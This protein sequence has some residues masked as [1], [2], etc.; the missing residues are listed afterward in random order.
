MRLWDRVQNLLG[1][2]ARQHHLIALRDGMIAVV[3]IILVGS[4]FLLLGSQSEVINGYFPGLAK[5]NFGIWYQNNFGILLAPF[6]FTMGMLSLY[7]AFT[8]A[9]SLAAQYK[10]PVLPQGMASVVAFLITIKPYN[11]PVEEGGKSVWLI[12][13]KPLGGDG[14]FLAIICGIFTVELSRG[15]NWLWNRLLQRGKKAD[16]AGEKE[17]DTG[18]SA[19][20][21]PKAVVDAFAS[22]LPMLSVVTLFWILCYSL[23]IDLYNG[24]IYLMRP[25][26]KMGDTL[27]CVVVVN[28]FLH[29]VGVAGV[30]GVSVINGVFL[31]LWQKFL[32]SNTEAHAAG[33]TLRYITSYPFYQWFVWIGGAGTTLP[34]PF[35]LLF[36][37]NAHMKRIGKVSLVPVLF[38][39]NEPVLFGLPVVANPLLAI[40][41]IL[42]PIVAGSVAFFAVSLGLV[43][44]PFI[45]V[46]WVLPAFLGAPLCNQ[47]I[48]S[49]ILLLVNMAISVLIWLPFLKAYEKK[50]S[51]EQ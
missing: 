18:G 8:I 11:I 12:P 20:G 48:R 39:I 33:E 24:L 40:P 13:M 37:K 2:M 10:L 16:P 6:R 38:N 1:M 28:L 51:S 22:F 35:L 14:L 26:E 23:N 21:I 17:E 27:P 5:S 3:P 34:I 41:F 49:L 4:T 15:V 44:K 46:P 29:V 7:V 50:L 31:A 32:L 36:F 30:H 19:L 25:L 42:A 47:D 43:T 45:E 9:A